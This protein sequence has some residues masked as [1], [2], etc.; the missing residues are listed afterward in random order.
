[1]SVTSALVF[2]SVPGEARERPNESRIELGDADRATRRLGI[3]VFVLTDNQHEPVSRAWFDERLA[4]A[5]RLFASIDVALN[6]VS[7]TP[8]SV[9]DAAVDTRAQRD[10]LGAGRPHQGAI[11]VYLVARLTDVDAPPQQIRGVHWRL[12]RDTTQRWIIMSSISGPM[13]LAHELG[14]FFSLPHGGEVASIMNKRP[15][16]WPPWE[17]RVFTAKEQ[18][19]MR[20]ALREMLTS[21]RLVVTPPR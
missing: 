18:A 7:W 12:R 15:R 13:V 19:R 4:Q 9:S 10:A 5:N 3:R 6:V 14:H 1:M 21:R 8:L 2:G 20:R 16:E 11:D 17:A